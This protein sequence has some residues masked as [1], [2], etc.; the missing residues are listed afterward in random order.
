MFLKF[1]QTLKVQHSSFGKAPLTLKH[2]SVVGSLQDAQMNELRVL[3][4]ETGSKMLGIRE[5]M[6]F[7]GGSD[8]KEFA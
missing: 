6:R 5:R 8:S 7:P 2:L 4:R 3:I 1:R